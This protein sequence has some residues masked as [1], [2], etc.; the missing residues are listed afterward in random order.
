M[1]RAREIAVLVITLLVA[2][3]ILLGFF[4][5]DQEDRHTTPE[6]TA[7]QN[8]GGIAP[9]DTQAAP[10]GGGPPGGTATESQNR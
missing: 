9:Y 2:G 8:Q 1:Y 5:F 4:A 3:A 6:R 7:E 10:D